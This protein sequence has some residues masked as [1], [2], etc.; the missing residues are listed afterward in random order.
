[1]IDM[2]NQDLKNKILKTLEG[3]PLYF[4]QISKKTG[5]S[6]NTVGKYVEILKAEG[7]VS[8]EDDYANVRLVSLKKR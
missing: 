7:E 5:L 8:V 6:L 2:A 1:M 4:T 3:R